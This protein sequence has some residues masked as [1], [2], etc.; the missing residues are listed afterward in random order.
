MNSDKRLP[1]VIGSLL[2]ETLVIE[3]LSLSVIE[4]QPMNTTGPTL[5]LAVPPSSAKHRSAATSGNTS[6]TS[7]TC[8]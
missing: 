3:S 4:R 1:L 6:I 5:A 7:T 8:G 2:V